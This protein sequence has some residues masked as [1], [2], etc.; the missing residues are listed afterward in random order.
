MEARKF[1]VSENFELGF[2][3]KLFVP[4]KFLV[5]AK[6]YLVVG[7]SKIIKKMFFEVCG[8]G[9]LKR[10]TRLSVFTE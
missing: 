7:N 4:S 8:L 5:L 6:F 1:L 10:T 9:K 2:F 3:C